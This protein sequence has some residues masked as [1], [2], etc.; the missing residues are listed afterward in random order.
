MST[1]KELLAAAEKELARLGVHAETL[2]VAYPEE[3]FV[4]EHKIEAM[5]CQGYDEDDDEETGL[6]SAEEL[7]HLFAQ[8]PVWVR[9]AAYS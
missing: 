9:N 5:L 3:Y 8:G 2:C 1:R 7:S 4:L 6:T